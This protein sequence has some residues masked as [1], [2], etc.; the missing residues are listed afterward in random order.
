LYS[1]VD[2]GIFS[3]PFFKTQLFNN[4]VK[5]PKEIDSSVCEYKFLLKFASIRATKTLGENGFVINSF[6]PMFKPFIM[7]SSASLADKIIMF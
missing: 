6:A 4:N 1:F 7:S 2:N 5:S 3:F